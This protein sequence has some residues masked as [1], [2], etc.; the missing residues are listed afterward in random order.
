MINLFEKIMGKSN[1]PDK[2][3]EKNLGVYGR[4]V[5]IRLK[6][7]DGW[8]KSFDDRLKKG[9]VDKNGYDSIAE[10]FMFFIGYFGVIRDK[11]K[12]EME[13]NKYGLRDVN[14]Q[15][16]RLERDLSSKKSELESGVKLKE[17]AT[18]EYDALKEKKDTLQKDAPEYLD[19]QEKYHNAK[20][21]KETVEASVRKNAM[22]CQN[23]TQAI[24]LMKVS[25]EQNK[26]SLQ[27]SE[28]ILKQ[29]GEAS[30]AVNAIYHKFFLLMRGGKKALQEA[31]DKNG[32]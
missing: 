14:I 2:D 25:S 6:E 31:G 19:I 5:Y 28:E 10:R 24:E 8:M 27:Q 12:E 1:N 15:V 32:A 26:L 29:V 16:K 18:K 4:E 11:L 20:K 3:I 9:E 21:E 17:I 13:L 30:D 22:L 7:A 23:F